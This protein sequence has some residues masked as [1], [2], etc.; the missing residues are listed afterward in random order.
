MT[1][2]QT[3]ALPIC[4]A[5]QRAFHWV[6]DNSLPLYLLHTTGM[7]IAVAVIFLTFDYLPPG[8]PTTE[9]WLTRPL[10]LAAPALATYPFLL[11]Y[12]VATRRKETRGAAVDLT[13]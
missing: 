6:N 1:G 7:A 11:L 4:P 3:C 5:W 10:W 13:S 12:Q 9:W 8:E 2:V